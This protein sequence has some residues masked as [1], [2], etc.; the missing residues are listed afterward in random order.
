MNYRTSIGLD[1]HA[2]SIRAA[3]FIPETGEIVERGFGYD[4]EAIAKWA[5]ALPQPARAVYESG[6]TG[7]NLCRSLEELGVECCV[8]AISKMLR[9]SGDKVKTDKRDATF[10]ARM[11]AVGNVVEVALPTPQMEA[12]RDLARARTDARCDLMRCRHRLSKMLLRKGIVYETGKKA[13]TK[14]HRKWLSSISFDNPVE[15]A[16]FDEYLDSVVAAEQ[17]RDRLDALIGSCVT[18]K[19]MSLSVAALSL[20]RGIGT[21]S[22]FSLKA[23]I[24]DFSRFP[25]ARSFM[26]YLGLTPSES[27][28]GE[29]TSR[30]KITRTGNL[31]ART[32]LVEAAWHQARTYKPLT[33]SANA[34][35]PAVPP[36]MAA[37]AHRANSRLHKRAMHFRDRNVSPSKANIAVAREMAGFIWALGCM[38]QE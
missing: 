29:G 10:L 19:P 13:W 3:A 37:C 22:A 11:L 18:E 12:Y 7:F 5:K 14:T 20:L 25:D 31:H 4:A 38:A 23:E 33:S 9:P 27:S 30:G 6:P 35:I 17:K 36:K 34:T 28:S 24:G 15:R 1:V 21:V 26:S 8:G 32:L 2:R 16:V